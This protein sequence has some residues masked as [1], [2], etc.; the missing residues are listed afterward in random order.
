MPAYVGIDVSKATLD[1]AVHGASE[2][3]AFANNPTGFRQLVAWLLPQH[4]PQVVLE[5]TA[6]TSSR[7]RCI[8][9]AGL[10]MARVTRANCV[11]SPRRSSI[12]Q[13][14]PAGSARVGAARCCC[15]ADAV[16]TALSLAAATDPVAS[17]AWPCG[18]DAR[19]RTPATRTPDRS[20]AARLG[21]APYRDAAA[22]A[23]S[24]R[25]RYEAP[26]RRATH[27]RAFTFDQG[28]RTGV[29]GHL[30]LPAS[31]TGTLRRQSD[32][33]VVGVAPLPATAA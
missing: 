31:G 24:S 6:V 28:P 17:A 2:V 1:V 26:G 9:I 21:K 4:P 7:A 32:C 16:S 25:H 8:V 15:A 3:R 22:R 30:G 33:Q 10:S 18:P 20:S 12:G 13:D 27:A 11:T 23:A 14:R 19:Q 5:A 29:A